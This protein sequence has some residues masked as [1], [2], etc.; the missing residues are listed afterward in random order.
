MVPEK[1][2]ETC[3]KIMTWL[4][5]EGLYKDKVC[6]EILYFH[7]AAEFP[8]RSGRHV[9]VIQPNNR[10][11]MVVVLSTIRLAEVHQRA[12]QVMAKKEREKFIWDMRYAL[13]FQ[14]ANF[15]MAPGGGE[16]SSIQF[17]R[18]IYYDGLTKNKLMEVLRANFKC[19]LFVVWKFQ[20]TF[21]DDPTASHIEQMYR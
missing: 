11:D 21:G 3:N 2:N 14:D 17:T 8:A 10:D 7:L 6:D 19:E 13:L 9:N 4:S 5:E 1:V 18:E 16:L 12:L 15:E 20:E